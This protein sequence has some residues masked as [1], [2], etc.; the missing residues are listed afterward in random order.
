MVDPAA[1]VGGLGRPAGQWI[2]DRAT[3]ATPST[4]RR[5]GRWPE[6]VAEA[7]D[8]G[9]GDVVV[10]VGASGDATTRAESEPAVVGTTGWRPGPTA[11]GA[12]LGDHGRSADNAHYVN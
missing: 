8:L 6:R 3:R 7:A 10:A 12:P 4:N 9:A 5:A 1:T 2:D 11:P